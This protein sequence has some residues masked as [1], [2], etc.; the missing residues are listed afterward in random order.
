MTQAADEVRALLE[1]LGKATADKDVE[2]ALD[3]YA[4]HPVV[5]AL[6]PP[7]RQEDDPEGEGLQAW[8]D[9]WDGPIGYSHH[10]IELAADGDVA[11]A[12]ALAHMSGTKID[13]ETPDLWFRATYG[14]R[15][16]DGAWKV[17]H[18]HLSTPF[19]MD[20]SFKAAVNL[21]P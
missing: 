10:D 7:L 12:H 20:G 3:C 5:F 18:E 9:T 8:F 1:R 14:L 4:P 19:L 17:A 13:G 11:F 16:L 21:K 15:R 2:A 6:P